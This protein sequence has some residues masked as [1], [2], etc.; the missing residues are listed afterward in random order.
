METINPDRRSFLGTA[1][2]GMGAIALGPSLVNMVG[3]VE[4]APVSSIAL[5]QLGDL[6]P[7]DANGIRLPVGFTS[8]VIAVSGENVPG[9]RFTWRAFPDGGA[10]FPTRLGGWIYTVNHEIPWP[11]GGVSALRFNPDGELVRAYSI[12]ERTN[13][14]CAGGPTPWGTWLSCEEV[15]RGNVWE[16]D[17]MGLRR[18][19]LIEAMG[20]FKHEAVA[21]DPVNVHFYLTEDEPDGRFY[22]FIPEALGRDGIPD[23][24]RGR[25]QAAVVEGD[26]QGAV[27]WVDVPNPNPGLLDTPTR[28]Q[29]PA[30]RAFDGGEG[31]WYHANQVVFTTKG[32][33]RVWRLD[34]PT[35]TLTVIYDDDLSDTPILTGVDNVTVSDSGEVLVA[36]DGGDM[37]IIVLA[38]DGSPRPLLQVE[39]Q[40]FSEITGPAFSPDGRRLYFNSQRGPGGDGKRRGITYE[41]TL[42]V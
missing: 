12:L 37:Q 6:Q 41:I 14:N 28:E 15:S 13:T 20:T 8:R 11:F 4:A 35:Q 19:R 36:E 1:A 23:L 39:N 16:C 31:I 25:L 17:A 24:S 3:V 21:Y 42:P 26:L 34:I 30:T 33:N 38:P 22:R 10:T 32:D 29:L 9:T 2:R 18:P 27:S 7:A 5:Y 40:E